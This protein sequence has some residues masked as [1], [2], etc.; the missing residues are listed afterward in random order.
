MR[1]IATLCALVM[2]FWT[3]AAMAT[4]PRTLSYQGLLKD[5]GGTVV[6]NGDYGI[7]FRIYDLPA[8]GASLWT[9]TQSVHVEDGVFSATLGT[10]VPLN[11]LFDVPYWI[12]IQV[13]SD[14][15]LPRVALTA[16]PYALRAVVADGVSG[17]VGDITAVTAGAGLTGG[18]TSGAVTLDVGAGTGIEVAADAVGLAAAYATG[19]AYDGRFVNEG[20]VNSV[21]AAMVTPDFVSSVDGVYNDGGNI[22]LV[23][24]ANITITPDDPNNRITIAATGGGGVG[25]S[26]TTDY[27]P[28]FTAATT[29]GNSAIT[30]TGGYVSISS[31]VQDNAETKPG[32]RSAGDDGRNTNKLYVSGIDRAVYGYINEQNANEDNRAAIY[33]IRYRALR[34][35]GSGYGVGLTN[36]AITGYNYWGDVYTFGVAGYSYNDYTR[37]GGVVGARD[38]AAYWGALG[39]KDENNG[40]WGV[41]TPNNAYVGGTLRLPSGASAGKALVTDGS[42][43]ASWQRVDYAGVADPFTI[44]TNVW[45][46]NITTG[47]LDIYQNDG[48]PSVYVNNAY[49]GG[50]GDA[51]WLNSQSDY[52]FTYTLNCN[53]RGGRSGFFSK[54][55]DD[56]QY[57]VYVDA[58]DEGLYVYGDFVV[59]GGTKSGVVETSQGQEAIFCVESPEVEIYASGEGQLSG[60]AAHVTFDRL[61]SE[62]ISTQIPVKVT[63]T[64]VGAW[65]GLYLTA[66]STAGFDVRAGAG[67]PN[68]AFHWMAC[69]RRAGFEARPQVT[70]PDRAEEERVRQ[71]K[72]AEVRNR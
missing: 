17:G 1:S 3:S 51:L 35:D 52:V 40:E 28:K 31:G 58:A 57:A 22:D 32:G 7:T 16:A 55:I 50:Y 67:D 56:D 10:A 60:G 37:T 23:A 41:Y 43:N 25:G 9:E 69:G 21:T 39:Y 49:T 46:V 70:I 13:L 47:E 20:Q 61:F 12:S 24:G 38:D 53:A 45:N 19:T 26:G 34:N 48:F 62:S 5:A 18:G 36:N 15:E 59:S 8:G 27:V 64:P 30:E 6:P 29:L 66:T 4:V 54:S 11:L 71:Q 33:G 68:V 63:V 65:S 42:G 72:E 14:P 2:V 44:G